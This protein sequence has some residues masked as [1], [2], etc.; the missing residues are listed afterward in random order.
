MNPKPALYAHAS[1]TQS[2]QHFTAH[3]E[4]GRDAQALLPPPLF[5]TT[6]TGLAPAETATREQNLVSQQSL[7]HTSDKEEKDPGTILGIPHNVK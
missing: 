6:R 7:Q 4:Q 3:P 2:L 1:G 5:S